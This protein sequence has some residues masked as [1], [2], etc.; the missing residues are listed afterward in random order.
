MGFLPVDA[1]IAIDEAGKIKGTKAKVEYLKKNMTPELKY[2]IEHAVSP[3]I[4]FG[5]KPDRVSFAVPLNTEDITGEAWRVMCTVLHKLK[6]TQLTGNAAIEAVSELSKH[7]NSKQQGLLYL[8]LNKDLRCG[9]GAKTANQIIPGLIKEFKVQLAVSGKDKQPT[10]PCL[11]EKKLNGIRS[12][13]V[14][15]NKT[16]THFS[17]SGKEQKGLEFLDIELL[18]IADGMDLVFDGEIHGISKD[19]R[20]SYKMAQELVGCKKQVDTTNILYTVFDMMPTGAWQ[21]QAY[22]E[23]Q[24]NRSVRLLNLIMDYHNN[25]RCEHTQVMFSRQHPIENQEQLDKLLKKTFKRG[26]EGL[27]VKDP[28]GEYKFKRDKSW[29][30]LKCHEDGEFKIV[31]V[32]EGKGKLKG[33]LAAIVVKNPKGKGTSHCGVKGFTHEDCKKLWKKRKK[34]IGKMATCE[35][36]NI[37]EDHALYLG[38]FTKIKIDEEK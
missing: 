32:I 6:S 26:G 24:A 12:I 38:K 1:F 19:H 34:L 27:I 15:S 23:I 17:R 25:E 31:D 21:R 37:T 5:L 18:R 10:F 4:N 22:P 3:F 13:A 2:V 20:K 16:V 28:K 35:Y 14:I 30:K 36:M 7:L 29:I 11:A 33:Q 9:I 8:I